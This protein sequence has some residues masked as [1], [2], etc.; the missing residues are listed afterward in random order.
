[1]ILICMFIPNYKNIVHI[2]RALSYFPLY[3]A[4]YEPFVLVVGILI[5]HQSAQITFKNPH[6]SAFLHLFFLLHHGNLLF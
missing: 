2:T 1:M 5:K 6:I 4:V 3:S